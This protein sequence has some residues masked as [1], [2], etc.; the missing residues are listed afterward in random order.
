MVEEDEVEDTASDVQVEFQRLPNHIKE[1][2]E[3]VNSIP[4]L[5]NFNQKN[6]S[7]LMSTDQTKISLMMQLRLIGRIN[8]IYSQIEQ[9]CYRKKDM[10]RLQTSQQQL[11]HF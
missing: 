1:Q 11:Y 10:T 9:E 4:A 3:E 5:R 8:N 6:K 7:L 2:L